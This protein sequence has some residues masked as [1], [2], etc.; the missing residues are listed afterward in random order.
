MTSNELLDAITRQYLKDNEEF[1][2]FAVVSLGLAVEELRTMLRQ[3]ITDELASIHLGPHPNP[4][5]KAFPAYPPEVQ[6]A[7]LGQL[8]DLNGV[9]AYPERRHLEGVVEHHDFRRTSV[10]TPHR[11]R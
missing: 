10:H 4:Y 6:I 7:A 11:A 8:G 2:G 5:I 1:N 9:I 3:L